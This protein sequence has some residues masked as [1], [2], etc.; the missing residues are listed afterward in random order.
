MPW[1]SCNGAD[2][3]CVLMRNLCAADTDYLKVDK[4]RFVINCSVYNRSRKIVV[5]V[6]HYTHDEAVVCARDETCK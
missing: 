6:L 3:P 5:E 1:H 4:M 2:N